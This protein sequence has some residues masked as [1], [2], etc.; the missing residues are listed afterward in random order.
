[1]FIKHDMTVHKSQNNKICPITSDNCKFSVVISE[2]SE[3]EIFVLL[4]SVL[5]LNSAR[6]D[7]TTSRSASRICPTVNVLVVEI[8][9]STGRSRPRTS[10]LQRLL[11]TCASFHS[12]HRQHQQHHPHHNYQAIQNNKNTHRPT[13]CIRPGA[14]AVKWKKKIY[15]KIYG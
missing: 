6:T 2:P 12:K 15:W 14:P 5:P 11:A 4:A 3:Q 1:M 9:A 10:E 8:P 13:V 7:C